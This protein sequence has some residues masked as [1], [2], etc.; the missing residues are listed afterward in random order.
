MVVLPLCKAMVVTE[1]PSY[2]TATPCKLSESRSGGLLLSVRG[3]FGAE[4]PNREDPNRPPL[5]VLF[6]FGADAFVAVRGFIEVRGL[7]VVSTPGSGSS[8]PQFSQL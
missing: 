3:P 1:G 6:E 8:E 7:L 2:T 5:L 4:F